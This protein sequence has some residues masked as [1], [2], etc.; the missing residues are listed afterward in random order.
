L[1]NPVTLFHLL[2]TAQIIFLSNVL[3]LLKWTVDP[4]QPDIKRISFR[5]RHEIRFASP[6]NANAY[7][8]GLDRS[9]AAPTASSLFF[10][11]FPGTIPYFSYSQR[12]IY[13]IDGE[14]DIVK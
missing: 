11:S 14:T 2:A 1:V 6:A 3:R 13:P 7:P 10:S 4:Y 12:V 8:G 9:A 5:S